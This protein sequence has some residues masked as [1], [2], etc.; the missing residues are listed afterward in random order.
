MRSMLAILPM[1]LLAAW[2]DDT[3][4]TP[5]ADP[6]APAAGPCGSDLVF[7][8]G[9]EDCDSSLQNF[10]GI[11]D[12]TVTE[13]ADPTNTDT[14]APNGRSTLCLPRTGTSQVT[15]TATGYLPARYT[16][17]PSAVADLY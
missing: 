12:A 2:S 15:F 9:Y 16:V 13:V 1:A 11:F 14:T 7:T 6:D 8:G 5:D 17:E 3:P 10:A 4:G